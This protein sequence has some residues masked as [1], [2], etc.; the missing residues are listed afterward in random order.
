SGNWE[1]WTVNLTGGE[2]KMIGLGVFPSWSPE[3]TVDRIAFQRARQRGSRWFSLWT[4]DLVD[5][6]A[7][8]VTEVAVSSNAAAVSP[9][10]SPDGKRSVFATIIDPSRSNGHRRGEQ[11]IRTVAADGRDRRRLTDGK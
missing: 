8:R 9:T 7:R 2:R 3:K 11:D 1:L 6:E 10:W 5:G 4:L